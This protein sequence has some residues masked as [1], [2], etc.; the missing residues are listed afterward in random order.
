[1]TVV[2]LASTKGGCGKTTAAVGLA[3]AF[4]LS[5][6][7]IAIVDGDPQQNAATWLRVFAASENVTLDP[8][9]L[10]WT[11]GQ[12]TVA[13]EVYEDRMVGT[14]I[15]LANRNDIVLVDTQGSANQSMLM[16][17]GRSDLVVVP[18]QPSRF[19]VAAAQRTMKIAEQASQLVGRDILVRILMSRTKPA[20]NTKAAR[21]VR[22]DLESAG[23]ILL[24]TELMDRTALQ[25][26]SITGVAPSPN[27]KNDAE[28]NAAEN[29]TWL[30]KEIGAIL[31]SARQGG[32]G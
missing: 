26:M 23:H 12:I 22:G 10:E 1:M 31:Y 25:Q 6:L 30:A 3:A 7:S 18:V 17:L 19:D 4:A 24:K 14:I 8:A 5:K 13:R 21:K 2:T 28:R 15:D 11:H 32:E 27:S 29:L 16:A 9:A 20:I